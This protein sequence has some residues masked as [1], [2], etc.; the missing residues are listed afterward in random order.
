M[1]CLYHEPRSLA[2]LPGKTRRLPTSDGAAMSLVVKRSF[3]T[4][5]DVVT[6]AVTRRRHCPGRSHAP[7][8][9]TANEEEVVLRLDTER[10]ELSGEAFDKSRV[11]R[12]VRKSLPLD[13]DSPLPER[14]EIW[15]PHIGPFRPRAYVDEL[16]SE[17]RTRALPRPWRY[18]PHPPRYR[19]QVRPIEAF[20]S[21]KFEHDVSTN[22]ERSTIGSSFAQINYMTAHRLRINIPQDFHPP[23]ARDKENL[24]RQ[25]PGTRY[26]IVKEGTSPFG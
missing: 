12:L 17:A 15:N 14:P 18:P 19:R 26:S 23:Y 9:R 2:L 22:W 7:A 8:S 1:H 10:L 25:Q 21:S 5:A 6:V 16:R 20:L 24:P 13:E 3:K 4:G 11:D